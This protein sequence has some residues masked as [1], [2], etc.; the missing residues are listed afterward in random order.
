MNEIICGNNVDVVKRMRTDTVNLTVTSPPYGD[1]RAYNGYNFD[2]EGIAEQ[3]YRVTKPC[4]AV[5][6]IVADQARDGDESGDSFRQTLFFKSLGFKL[7]DT[8]IYEKSPNGA[9][10]NK[11]GYW[12]TF[13][14]MFG[15]SKGRLDTINLLIDRRNVEEGTGGYTKRLR[16][17]SMKP[18][19]PV[20]GRYG[21]RTN[22][23]KYN[24]GKEHSSTDDLARGHPAIF[25]E[26]LASDHIISWSN[27]N[28][29]VLDPFCG[30][31]TTCKMAKLLN[32]RYIGIDVSEE[33]CK[34]ARKRVALAEQ[35]A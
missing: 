21:R 14:Y 30:S 29:L 15:F 26:K 10:G 32:R 23:W 28:D 3:L 24:T 2:F 18:T 6:W 13:E 4:C 7:F 8:I 35:T 20:H 16:D 5:V 11:R 1:A 12:Q 19:K 22:V 27:E 34:I 31:G 17:G 33:Y 25:P 9:V